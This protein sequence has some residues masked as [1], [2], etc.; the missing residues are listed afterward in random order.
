M[1][2]IINVDIQ[3]NLD[4]NKYKVQFNRLGGTEF[5]M[6][7]NILKPILEN[8]IQ[9]VDDNIEDSGIDSTDEVIKIIN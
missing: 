5:E 6:D 9:G 1:S 3:I 8:I 7:W 2:R 4:E